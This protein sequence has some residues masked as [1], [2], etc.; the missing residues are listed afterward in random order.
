MGS[1]AKRMRELLGGT[2]TAGR[3]LLWLVAGVT[4]IR[5]ALVFATPL[6]LY[7][8]EAQYWV[9]S[10]DL[11][12]G[13][14]SKP[15]VIAWLIHLT[16]ALAGNG[17]A[18]VRLA[19]P[20]L[21]GGAG[22]ALGATGRR[23]YGG[24]TGVVAAA[25]YLLMPGTMLSSLVIATDAPLLMFSSLGLLI[26]VALGDEPDAGGRRALLLAMGL[27]IATGLAFLSKYAA[28]YLAGGIALHAAV[29]RDARLRW[30]P[31][32]LSAVMAACL[33]VIAPN[34][35]W[36][37]S[38]HFQTLAHA[39]DN[40]DVTGASKR[41]ALTDPRGGLGFIIGQFGVFGP[42]PF[43]VLAGGAAWL[44]WRRR[45]EAAD[46]LLLCFIIPP[47]ILI[48]GEAFIVRA[49]ANWAGAAYPAAAILTAGMLT[50]WRAMRTLWVAVGTGALISL[51]FGAVMI[52][53]ALADR[54][55][56]ANS[57]KR[58]RGWRVEA[59]AVTAQT[60][61][62]HYSAVAVDE[63]FLFNALAYYGRGGRGQSGGGYGTPLL[64][65]VRGGKPANQAEASAPLTT[66]YGE[67]VLLAFGSEEALASAAKNFVAVTPI[68]TVPVA[69]DRKHS[70]TLILAEGRGYHPSGVALPY[71]GTSPQSALR[72]LSRPQPTR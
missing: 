25:L 57:L 64:V 59:Q 68:R 49:N 43:A 29:I 26:Y 12:F 47:L 17:E 10:R 46:R 42:V 44:V 45:M 3:S 50:R 30:R 8:D 19:A 24:W 33:A 38:H 66:A 53:P 54:L 31:L 7:P 72:T 13:Y 23:L 5:L 39:V 67:R 15:P 16:T 56:A 20:L 21:H 34:L 11:A 70:R 36:N 52:S 2:L 6:E 35:L 63:R 55:G 58:A 61:S 65:W 4:L 28:L 18:G 22:L 27:G 40:A 71:F 62:S 60:A 1:A 51:V 14:F 41:V 48:W 69:L 9:W 32:T 37:A